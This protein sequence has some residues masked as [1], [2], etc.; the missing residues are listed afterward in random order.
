MRQRT[1]LLAFV[2][3]LAAFVVTI[4]FAARTVLG[5][6]IPRPQLE[7]LKKG[8]TKSEVRAILGDP[9]VIDGSQW[10]YTRWANPGWVEVYFDADER[11]RNV[12]DES[13]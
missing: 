8:M 12:N 1:T 4:A 5:P 2:A 10:I 6:V 9:K 13:T 11:F 3:F 7:Q